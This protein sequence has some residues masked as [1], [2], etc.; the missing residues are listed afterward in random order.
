MLTDDH[1]AMLMF[2]M[3]LKTS[4]LPLEVNNLSLEDDDHS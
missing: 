1:F 4:L 2:F 3:V